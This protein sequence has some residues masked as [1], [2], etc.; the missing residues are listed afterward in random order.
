M[1]NTLLAAL[2]LVFIFEG[3]LPF[4]FPEFWRRVM[5]EATRMPEMQ[6]RLMGLLSLSVGMVL[7]LIFS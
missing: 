7:L 2:A 3:L 5:S 6:L 4:A 1:E